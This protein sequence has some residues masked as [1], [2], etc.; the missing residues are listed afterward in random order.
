MEALDARLSLLPTDSL[1]CHIFLFSS[2]PSPID[3]AFLLRALFCELAELDAFLIPDLPLG[4][5][6]TLLSI[7]SPLLKP[8]RFLTS[9]S[10]IL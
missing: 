1:L 7:D 8:L 2:R 4:V 5:S 6:S 10:V 9:S 3:T